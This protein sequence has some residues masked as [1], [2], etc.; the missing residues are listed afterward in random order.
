MT[1]KQFEKQMKEL[2]PNTKLVLKE[3]IVKSFNYKPVYE[4]VKKIDRSIG[5][6]HFENLKE[7]ELGGAIK[8]HRG[9]DGVYFSAEKKVSVDACNLGNPKLVDDFL[10]KEAAYDRMDL[11]NDEVHLAY[12]DEHSLKNS[13]KCQS[14]YN[15]TFVVYHKYKLAFEKI[16]R[17][18]VAKIEWILSHEMGHHLFRNNSYVKPVVNSFYKLNNKTIVE[19]YNLVDYDYGSSDSEEFFAETFSRYL[20]GRISSKNIGYKL[21]K[22]MDMVIKQLKGR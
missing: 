21:F 2:L 6:E 1:K 16:K 9:D 11:I 3:K 12:E 15:K 18:R 10:E 4:I 17:Y 8:N 20:A 19:Y 22:F 13:R 5:L 14:I 7:I